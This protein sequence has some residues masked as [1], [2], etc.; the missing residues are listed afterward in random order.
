MDEA[1]SFKKGRW[2]QLMTIFLMLS[3]LPRNQ[4]AGESSNIN[5]FQTYDPFKNTELNSVLSYTHST[6]TGFSLSHRDKL[7]MMEQSLVVPCA[8]S[9]SNGMTV[10]GHGEES[11]TWVSCLQE[12][13][14]RRLTFQGQTPCTVLGFVHS[15]IKLVSS[16]NKS[17]EGNKITFKMAVDLRIA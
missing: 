11:H 9:G 15:R 6:P 7:R 2:T 8:F 16:F 12:D 10:P 14:S 5:Y 3:Y 17:A 4:P 13:S 1:F